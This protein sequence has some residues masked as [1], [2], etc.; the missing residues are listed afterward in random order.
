MNAF[1][2][3][4][5]MGRGRRGMKLLDKGREWRLLGLMYADDLVLCG[6]SEDDLRAM[7]RRFVVVCRRR[8]LEV[9]AGKSK[10]MGMNG[11]K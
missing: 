4:V 7:V 3:E 5:K 11:E 6:E 2:K 10:V 9:S 8:G 1:M